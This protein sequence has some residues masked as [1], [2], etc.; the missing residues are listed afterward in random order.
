MQLFHSCIASQLLI[1]IVSKG[2]KGVRLFG[3]IL[4]CSESTSMDGV[5]SIHISMTLGPLEK[6]G[7]ASCSTSGNG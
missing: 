4:G 3:I 2:D 7:M 5:I 1:I 6:S